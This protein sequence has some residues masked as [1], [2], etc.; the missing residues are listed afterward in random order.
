MLWLR[1]SIVNLK[2]GKQIDVCVF[3]RFF[4]GAGLS[5]GSGDTFN[6]KISKFGFHFLDGDDGGHDIGKESNGVG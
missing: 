6:W 1:I 3:L 2:K 5:V 4:F